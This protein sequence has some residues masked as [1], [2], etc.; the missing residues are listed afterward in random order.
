ML[1]YSKLRI[2]KPA[3]PPCDSAFHFCIQVKVGH[4]TLI[5]TRYGTP[6]TVPIPVLKQYTAPTL[7]PEL[8]P[9]SKQSAKLFLQSSELGL[10]IPTTS[11]AGGCVSP[12][13]PPVPGRGILACGRGGGGVP[14]RT[15]VQTLV[16]K[17]YMVP[18]LRGCDHLDPKF[19]GLPDPDPSLFIQKNLDFYCFATCLW[20]FT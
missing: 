16:L 8:W 7:Q 5:G 3:H 20:L 9:Q 15:R 12:P 17:V 18:I 4:L 2:Q 6:G 10:P 19:L 13:P 11:H 1:R 14:L